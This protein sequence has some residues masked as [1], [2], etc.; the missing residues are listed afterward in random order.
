MR[1]AITALSYAGLLIPLLG[2]A[3]TQIPDSQVTPSALEAR[4]ARIE[5]GF[6]P[7]PVAGQE[8]LRL[9]IRKLMKMYNV[10]GLSVAVIDDYRI[11]W[12]KGYGVTAP[13]GDTPVN[14]RT[15]FQAGSL[16]K[17]VAAAGT[18]YLVQT[19][20]LSLDEDVD[21]KL[22]SW[23]VPAN[24]YTR[25]Q[26][27]TLRRI[28]SHSAGFNVHGFDGYD[29]DAPHPTLLQ[30]LD[31]VAPA[32]SPS[33]KVGRVPGSEW[34][35][36]GGGVLVEQQL[37]LDVS[38]MSFPQ[39]MQQTVFGKLD[40][41][42]STYEQPLPTARAVVAARGTYFDGKPVHGG[43]HVYPEMAAAG[44]WTTPTDLA[45]FSIE[46]ARAKQGKSARV[47]SKQMATEMLTPQMPRV[48]E[49]TWGDAEHPDRM[50]LGFFLGD[51][52]RP[53]RF[54]HI[55]DDEG[56]QA[57]MI[58][59][60]DSGQGAVIM[61]NSAQG[62]RVGRLLLANIAEEY[63]WNYTPPEGRVGTGTALYAVAAY[64]GLPAALDLYRRFEKTPDPSDPVD[65]K[66]LISL[67]Y[68]LSWGNDMPD[69]IRVMRLAVHEYPDYWNAYDS[70]GEM[71]MMSGDKQKAIENYTRSVQLNP[72]NQ[73]G[74]DAL[75]DLQSQ[76]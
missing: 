64:R 4:I 42:D 46:I 21:R 63:A 44:L 74:K 2:W 17:P 54:G 9:D 24:D 51:A 53:D 41:Q 71:Y 69:A 47:L 7:I 59:F 38:H 12:A 32:N 36:S 25:D 72:D 43:W 15:L 6:A 14:V 61:A 75:Q 30:V 76:H 73:G 11:A 3:S 28:M 5:T 48:E 19:G 50:G 55:G 16:S 18:L 58:M 49:D 56:F 34:H 57:M 39:F 8:P 1:R 68:N 52:T 37:V 10:P 65:R 45:K 26:K 29:V 22:T 33:V 67:G 66:T 31:G 40:M 62:I 60:G 13:G 35:Y 27:V 20:K 23:H 70:L